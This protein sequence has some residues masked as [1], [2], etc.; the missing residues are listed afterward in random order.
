M[1]TILFF[2]VFSFFVVNFCKHFPPFAV[3][4]ENSIDNDGVKHL[5]D[6]LKVNTTLTSLDLS[7]ELCLFVFIFSVRPCALTYRMS[8]FAAL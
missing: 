5:A 7:C 6:M 3:R 4:L 2:H 8:I 1:A